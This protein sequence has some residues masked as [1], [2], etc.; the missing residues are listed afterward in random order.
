MTSQACFIEGFPKLPKLSDKSRMALRRLNRTAEQK[1]KDKESNRLRMAKKMKEMT[2][3]Q[4]K[5]QE[6]KAR[7]RAA[8]KKPSRFVITK[9][10]VKKKYIEHEREFNRL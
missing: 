2:E 1:A 10:V 7:R 5:N 4:K 9:S 8:K 3:D 6:S